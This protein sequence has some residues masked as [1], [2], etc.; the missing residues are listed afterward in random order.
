[1][2]AAASKQAAAPVMILHHHHF[3]LRRLHSLT[4]LVPIGVFIIFHLFTNAQ[5]IIPDNFQHE[6]QFIHSLPVLIFIEVFGLWLPIAFHAGLGILYT[7]SGKSNNRLYPYYD[8]LRYT[9]QRITGIIALLFICFHIATL[10]WRLDLG[11][12][13]TPF[14][15]ECELP[16]GR[17]IPLAHASTAIALQISPWIVLFYIAGNLS[18]IFHFANGLW[19]ASISWGLTVSAQAQ[20]RWG[21]ICTILFFL[22]FSLFSAAM[23][24]ALRY[25]PTDDE[26]MAYQY[27]LNE[28]AFDKQEIA[29]REEVTNIDV[30][31]E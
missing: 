12:W 15:L 10:R 18:A 31:I 8:N 30:T 28:K 14:F 21:Y 27:L 17:I 5:M 26:Y 22:L 6:V 3:L 2:P 24:G 11:I 16:D 9:T 13:H 25:Q 20:R 4:G 23:Q 29:A 1:V 19:T 7:F